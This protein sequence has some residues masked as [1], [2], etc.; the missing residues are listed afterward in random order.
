[1]KKILSAFALTLVGALATTL[2]VPVA[3]A[4]SSSSGSSV[5]G[6]SSSSDSAGKPSPPRTPW[7]ETISEGLVVNLIGDLLGPGISDHVGFMSGDLGT[8]T[9]LGE[10]EEFAIIFGDSFRGARFGQ[11]EW[12]SP[13][14]VVA[15]LDEEGRIVITR[16]LND[17]AE[18]KQ[19][20][21]YRHNERGLTLLPSDVINIDGTLYM[22]AM[23]NEG[24]GNVRRTQIW[25]SKDQGQSWQSVSITPA[26]YL[27][28]KANLITWDLGP[29]G[30]VYMMSS[31]FKRADDVYL[32]RFRP[33]DIGDRKAWQHYHLHQD[34][35]GTWGRTA[36]PVLD[37]K[38]RAGEMSLRYIED[39]WV[40]AMFNAETMA[41]EVRISE[42]ID[43]DWN[44]IAPAN[45]IVSGYGGWREEQTPLNFTQL[46]GAYITPTSTLDNL[47][48]V[49]SQWNTS[50]N[51]RYMST[52]FNVQGLDTFFGINPGSP[53]SRTFSL[54]QD[55]T[56]DQSVIEVKEQEV[57][58]QTREELA[59]EQ[60]MEESTDLSFIPLD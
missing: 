60:L 19:L 11:G 7:T 12:I 44:E 17:D 26:S 59:V 6:S 54:Q 5:F 2:P 29:D 4:Q 27:G 30:Y 47:D 3:H 41:I 49:V 24:V 25:S 15:E 57:D 40:L 36:T 13:V 56:G 37:E 35:T 18:V 38:V 21:D 9:W 22:Q 31:A 48:L 20:I 42:T 8:M 10:G 45:V 16:P 28:G 32:A 43:R 51:S 14:G 55:R 58:D 34:G 52:Q 23:W 46:Y 33:E 50:N 39:H 53:E 1:M